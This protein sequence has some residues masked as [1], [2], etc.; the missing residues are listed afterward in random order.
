MCTLLFYRIQCDIIFC[1]WSLGY[2]ESDVQ[3]SAEPRWIHNSIVNHSHSVL[4]VIHCCRVWKLFTIMRFALKRCS[5]NK[6]NEMVWHPFPESPL[7]PCSHSTFAFASNFKNGFYGNKWWCSYL[8]FTFDGKDQRKTQTQ[9]EKGFKV[10]S[11]YA[12]F[13]LLFAIWRKHKEW[14]QFPFSAF[15]T[16][17]H[18][19]NVAIWCKRRRRRKR[20]GIVWMRL[21]MISKLMMMSQTPRMNDP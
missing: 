3:T 6:Y 13:A 18:R 19:C 11:H 7:K 21:N 8:T 10:R 20:T 5:R 17:S 2:P 1:S 14:V 15:D 12:F 4:R 16:T 9:C